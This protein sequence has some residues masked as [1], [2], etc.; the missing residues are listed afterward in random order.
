M[1]HTSTQTKHR[2]IPVTDQVSFSLNVL[3]N[4]ESQYLKCFGISDL[5]IYT[6]RDPI[7]SMKQHLN[8]V[9]KSKSKPTRGIFYSVRQ[10]YDLI[11]ML[12]SM[13]V[14][15]DDFVKDFEILCCNLLS[16]DRLYM[17]IVKKIF[18]CPI[19][20]PV[21]AIPEAT[22]GYDLH[23]NG[24]YTLDPSS[25]YFEFVEV[26]ESYF[27]DKL[28]KTKSFRNLE[29]GGLYEIV[30][31][32]IHTDCIRALTREIVKIVNYDGYTPVLLSICRKAE[33]I[34]TNINIITTLDLERVFEESGLSVIEYGF[35]LDGSMYKFYLEL[36]G[37]FD[38]SSNITA[39]LR[40]LLNTNTE[41]R[42]V[43]PNTFR[44][45]IESNKIDAIDPYC[46]RLCR[47]IEDVDSMDLI[48]K[49]IIYQF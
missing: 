4:N 22:I 8:S 7:E 9:L 36:E 19:Y 38:K 45:I 25:A 39:K 43:E 10:I 35:R 15:I 13:D 24:T 42:I 48:K 47:S 3:L 29:I 1:L 14:D 18:N 49:S 21:F 31:T 26:N 33:L 28:N 46:Y 34:Y 30:V 6:I 27:K 12:K 32:N 17:K 20:C 16:S 5:S 11:S 37:K 40:E 2:A 23:F 44:S 41:V